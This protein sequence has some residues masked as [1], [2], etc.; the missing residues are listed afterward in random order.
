MHN[1]QDLNEK[2]WR[3]LW[4]T[5]FYISPSRATGALNG[6]TINATMYYVLSQVRA[7]LHEVGVPQ[8]EVDEANKVLNFADGCYGGH[9]TL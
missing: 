7:P 4:T 2:A 3:D 1:F 5:G 6:Y 9:H 8:R